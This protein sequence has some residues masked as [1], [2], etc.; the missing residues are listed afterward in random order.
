M[1]ETYDI[2][3]GRFR[4]SFFYIVRKETGVYAVCTAEGQEAIPEL[5]A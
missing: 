3:K 1:I 2:K 5:I 4:A